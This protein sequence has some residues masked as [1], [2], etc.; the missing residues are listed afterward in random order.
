MRRS[1]ELDVTESYTEIWWSLMAYEFP[2]DYA[3]AGALAY[4]NSM[5]PPNL[6]EILSRT[7]ELIENP[8]QRDE[9]FGILALEMSRRGPRHPKGKAAIR[10]MN[11]IHRNA[12]K[13]INQGGRKR[14]SI[15]NEEYLFV[16]ATS[17]VVQV[18]WVERYG[19]RRLGAHE[20]EAA[21]LHFRHQGELMG[22]KDIP[23]SFSEFARFH[24]EYI[25]A[26]FAYSPQ[27]AALFQANQDMV[28]NVLLERMPQWALPLGRRCA[29]GL[30]PAL[31]APHQR[32]AFGVR[33]PSALLRFAV[34]LAIKARSSYVRSLPPREE[35][36]YPDPFPTPTFPDGEYELDRVGP[37]HTT[38][39]CP[40]R[41]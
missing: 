1:H 25:K 11:Q 29:R 9:H 38:G 41:R 12:I 17:M 28:L 19:W 34:H 39:V 5:A 16:L 33:T 18:R 32:K 35:P 4:Y 22:L 30:I 8:Q 3:M 36:A 21:Y 24:D 14:Y 27:A 40:F 13:H 20:Y 7:G 15:S 2:W 37:A 23:G 31:L 10:R 6:A 26:N